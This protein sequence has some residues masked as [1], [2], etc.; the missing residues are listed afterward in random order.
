MNKFNRFI[1]LADPHWGILIKGN[2]SDEPL[3]VDV[4][5]GDQKETL[6]FHQNGT[7]KVWKS[8]IGF[9]YKTISVKKIIRFLKQKKNP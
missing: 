8:K 4:L 1:N 6:V 3:F 5:I 9:I 7:I 2:Q